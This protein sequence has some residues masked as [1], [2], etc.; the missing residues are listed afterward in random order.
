MTEMAQR[1]RY[2]MEAV[3]QRSSFGGLKLGTKCTPRHKNRR[4]QEQQQGSL[5]ASLLDIFFL[6]HVPTH[7]HTEL[8]TYLKV[9]KYTKAM[10]K[11]KKYV[12]VL[13]ILNH[14]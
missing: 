7:Q 2:T 1:P 12:R 13:L 9:R 8:D 10:L 5:V 4:L 3:F 14:D 6:L 11:E